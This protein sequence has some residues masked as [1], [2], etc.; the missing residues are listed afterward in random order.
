MANELNDAN[1]TP[2]TETKPEQTTAPDTKDLEAKIKE[3]LEDVYPNI[4]VSFEEK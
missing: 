1:K 3:R 2:E 4:P